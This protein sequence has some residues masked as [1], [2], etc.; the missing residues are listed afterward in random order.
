MP[1]FS[2]G[3]RYHGRAI[4][5]N[6]GQ[7]SSLVVGSITSPWRGDFPLGDSLVEAVLHGD[8][9]TSPGAYNGKK[10]VTSGELSWVCLRTA[11][12]SVIERRF[13]T[14]ALYISY[15]DNWF[16][17][18]FGD[19]LKWTKLNEAPWPLSRCG[20]G[21][22]KVQEPLVLVRASASPGQEVGLIVTSSRFG[23]VFLG[24]RFYLIWNNRPLH[25]FI[26]FRTTWYHC[27]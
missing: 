18:L 11:S 21:E 25:G 7:Q 20:E 17:S 22:N 2:G 5:A 9:K 14:P 10:T 24:D 26:S 27:P 3:A 1:I 19:P 16:S 8:S 15:R 6:K 12:P 13:P 4:V 23:W